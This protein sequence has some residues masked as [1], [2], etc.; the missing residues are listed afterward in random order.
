MNPITIELDKKNGFLVRQG[1]KYA[2]CLCWDEMMGLVTELSIPRD[3]SRTRW[4]M[5]KEK[6]EV[7]EPWLRKDREDKPKEILLLK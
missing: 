4:M 6:H 3:F 7:A 1:D 2:D 5:T